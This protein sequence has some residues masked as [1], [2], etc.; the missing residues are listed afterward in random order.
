MTSSSLSIFCVLESDGSFGKLQGAVCMTECER[1]G[2]EVRGLHLIGS[3]DAHA[4]R[5]AANS[6][7]Q[8]T[9]TREIA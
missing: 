9:M 6:P 2:S 7:I 5:A 3:R 1:L 4:E 8:Y